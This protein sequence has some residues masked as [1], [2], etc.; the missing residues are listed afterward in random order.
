MK[1]PA[2]SVYDVKASANEVPWF[3][4]N[5]ATA[6]RYF[7]DLV[8]RPD[9]PYNLHPEDYSLWNVGYFSTDSRELLGE[10]PKLLVEGAHAKERP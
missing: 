7:T 4:R 9:H 6:T 5:D 2:Y 8:N 3:H 10:L 1:T